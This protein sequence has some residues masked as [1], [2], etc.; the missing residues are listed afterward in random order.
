MARAKREI[1][2]EIGK[3]LKIAVDRTIEREK[4]KGR[5]DFTQKK[6]AEEI[7]H[8]TP[9]HLSAMINGSRNL[10][11]DSARIV[12]NYDPETT[13]PWLLHTELQ[14]EA[15]N[16]YF[17]TWQCAEELIFSRGYSIESEDESDERSRVIITTP[18]RAKYTITPDRYTL[19]LKN[20]NAVVEG[21]L[22][23]EIQLS[24]AAE[25]EKG[26]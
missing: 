1:D 4:A 25:K 10:T 24:R 13:L 7:L 2:P 18:D 6:Y 12:V 5:K 22:L 26:A 20:I 8:C 17:K 15:I 21:L 3:R 14:N 19:L 23:Y 16:R 11:I 9:E